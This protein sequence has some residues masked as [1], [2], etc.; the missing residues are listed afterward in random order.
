MIV[1]QRHPAEYWEGV[2]EDF[3]PVASR[4]KPMRKSI[5]FAGQRY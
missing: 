2:I 5:T 1:K 3:W 4:K